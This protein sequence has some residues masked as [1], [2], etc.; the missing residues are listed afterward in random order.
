MESLAVLQCWH[1]FHFPKNTSK[2]FVL[3]K[4]WPKKFK[5]GP[6]NIVSV[7]LAVEVT[8][9]ITKNNCIGDV[10]QFIHDETLYDISKICI[11]GKNLGTFDLI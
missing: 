4:Q 8:E 9:F 1:M 7:L 10:I 3:S 5:C 11:E 6:I 2:V